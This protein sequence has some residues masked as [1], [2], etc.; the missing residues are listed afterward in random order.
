MLA[1]L[2]LTCKYWGANVEWVGLMI[3]AAADTGVRGVI[4]AIGKLLG[5]FSLFYADEAVAAIVLLFVLRRVSTNKSLQQA[6][7]ITMTCK[8]FSVVVGSFLITVLLNVL[9]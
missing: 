6:V 5:M 8:V 9:Y 7:P 2:A 1:A 4:G 3:A